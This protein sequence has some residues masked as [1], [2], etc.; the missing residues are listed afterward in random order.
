MRIAALV[1][2]IVGGL[3]GIGAGLLVILTSSGSGFTVGSVKPEF[4]FA[5]GWAAFP[6]SMMGIVGGALAVAKPKVAGILMLIS[7]VGGALVIALGY[8]IS[9]P[10]LLTGG[11]LALQ[12]E[13][14]S[15]ADRIE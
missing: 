14:R 11:I 7:A 2:G 15:K 3:L 8:T 12:S 10:L 13:G 5:L 1:L 9:A 6:L 4:I